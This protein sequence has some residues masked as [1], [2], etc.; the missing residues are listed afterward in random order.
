ME[1]DFEGD[2]EVD[3]EG[4]MKGNGTPKQRGLQRE[5]KQDMEGDML[6]NSGRVRS[7]SGLVKSVFPRLRVTNKS[8]K[9][10][11]KSLKMCLIMFYWTLVDYPMFFTV[12]LLLDYGYLKDTHGNFTL[13][14]SI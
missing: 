14:A 8:S 2:L 12:L 3:L 1:K 13:R 4:E 11:S 9:D 6:S 5:F 10:H 7:R